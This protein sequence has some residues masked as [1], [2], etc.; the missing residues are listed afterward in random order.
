MLAATYLVYTSQVRFHR[1]IYAVIKVLVVWLSLKT[2]CSKVL[3]WF[4]DHNCLAGFMTRSRWTK[5]TAMASFQ[6][7]W[8]VEVVVAPTDLLLILLK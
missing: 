3:T 2:L 5:E 6:Q 4:S 7:D 8:C 1:V